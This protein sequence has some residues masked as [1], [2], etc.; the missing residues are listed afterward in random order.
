MTLA[1]RRQV[2]LD[3]TLDHHVIARCVRSAWLTG[4]DPVTGRNFNHRK[5]WVVERAKELAGVF[6]IR[7]HA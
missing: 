4:D 7:I 5:Q 2:D 3:A 6:A 1:R